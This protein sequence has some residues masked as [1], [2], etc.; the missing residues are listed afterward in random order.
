MNEFIPLGTKILLK[1]FIQPK[2]KAS[3]LVIDQKQKPLA[4]VVET[5]SEVKYEFN[6]DDLVR[7]SPY[8]PISIDEDNPDLI[9]VDEKEILCIVRLK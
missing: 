3:L 9:L 7:Y 4:R 8:S 5:G 6:R 2:K 1:K